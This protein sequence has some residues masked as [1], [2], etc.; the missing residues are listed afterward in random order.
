[1]GLLNLLSTIKINLE[2]KEW[3]HCLASVVQLVEPHP[4]HQKV[5]GS[6][7]G[8][9]CH[10]PWAVGEGGGGAHLSEIMQ[11]LWDES[12]LYRGLLFF[13]FTRPLNSP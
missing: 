9:S 7:P 13:F 3:Q 10:S 11:S 5:A 8:Q 1:M 2:R 6:I 12:R 4:M